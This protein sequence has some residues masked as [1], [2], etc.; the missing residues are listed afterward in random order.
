MQGGSGAV[1]LVADTARV[2]GRVSEKTVLSFESGELWSRP[3]DLGLVRET[4]EAARRRVH[5]RERRGAAGRETTERG[6]MTITSGQVIAARKMLNWS[7]SDLAAYVGATKASIMAFESR[8]RW[9]VDL[10]L[11]LIRA[12]YEDSGVEFG[13][14][15]ADVRL[16]K[17]SK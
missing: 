13:G 10:D 2:S 5:R 14:G 3:L 1:G 11:D 12:V 9:P 15:G 7:Q 17:G 8:E 4:L 16:R 6:E